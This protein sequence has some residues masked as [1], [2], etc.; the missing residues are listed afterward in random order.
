VYRGLVRATV[1]CLK[2]D[3]AASARYA[4]Q[5]LSWTRPAAPCLAITHG[6]PGSGKTWRS[7]RWL[8]A[9]G[10]IRVRSDVE[11]K[12]L[13]G[14]D[15]LADSRA[16]GIDIY[17]GDATNRTYARLLSLARI[18][19]QA[20]WPVVLDAAFLRIQ[21]RQAA[22]ELAE[23]TGAAFRILDCDAPP[24]V[25]RERLARRR[26]DASEADEAVLDKLRESAQ[27]LTPQELEF[28]AAQ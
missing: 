18:A 4:A 24:E 12:R 15:A 5:V 17:R 9:H 28:R 7:Q 13:F 20:G 8:E 14:L 6:L 16:H 1:A 22:R 19:L 23:E 11:R 2:N 27:A 25:L 26:G 21:E 3:G 10:A